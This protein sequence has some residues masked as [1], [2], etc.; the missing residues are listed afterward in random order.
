M[1]QN[2]HEFID[3]LLFAE[4]LECD[5]FVNTVIGP[6]N[7]SLFT[8]PA[9]EMLHIANEIEK[10]GQKVEKKFR[11]NHHVWKDNII[12]LRGKSSEGQA[13]HV[14][15]IID[16]HYN[17]QDPLTAAWNLANVGRK[18]EAL[19]EARKVQKGDP[20]FYRAVAFCGRLQRDLGEWEA[21]EVDLQRAIKMSAKRPEAFI[22]LAQLRLDQNRP[23]EAL[24]SALQAHKLV[25]EE[26]LLEVETCS[27]LAPIYIELGNFA[28]A[29]KVLMRLEHLQPKNH[30]ISF[31]RAKIF[32][33]TGMPER[34]LE[35]L[36]KALAIDPDHPE[37][38]HLKREL[39]TLPTSEAVDTS[40]LNA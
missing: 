38:N 13:E 9:D 36:E 21:A 5:L 2:W 28:E 15:K 24:D 8:L 26:D 37:A 19:E 6:S 18:K 14:R 34:A 11:R 23:Q 22:Y 33:L 25:K 35:E 32:R 1:R 30:E 17:R 27:I 4:E 29:L 10:R 7:C 12:K 31:Q 20:T 16:T 39:Q 3:M 40:D